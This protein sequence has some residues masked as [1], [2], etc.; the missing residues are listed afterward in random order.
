MGFDE[1]SQFNE[2]Q[3]LYITAQNRGT[4]ESKIRCYVRATFNPGGIGHAWVKKRFIDTLFDPVTPRRVQKKYFKRVDDEDVETDQFDKD[5]LSRSFV[6]STLHDNPSIAQDYL[7][8]L[9][10][11]STA[12][13]KAFIE[14][15]WDSFQGQFFKMWRKP[16]HVQRKEINPHYSKFLSL[17]YGYGAPA[18][19]GWWQIDYDGNLHRYRE[20]Y[21]EG[22]TYEALARKVR[23]MTPEGEII[24][25]CVADPAI[26]GD[27]THHRDAIEGQ[28]GAETMNS[29]WNGFTTLV[30]ADNDRIIGWGRLRERM[31]PNDKGIVGIS[32]SPECRD[33][34]RTIPTLIHDETDV[35][36]LN[37][38]GE[39]HAADEWRYAVMSRP[40]ATQK[41]E[42]K[43]EKGSLEYY[44]Q[45][46]EYQ[47]LM[48]ELE[49]A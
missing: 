6:F 26:W 33:S 17:D 12:D 19:V 28:S 14:G 48:K 31:T 37:T 5:A 15:D 3:Y 20:F 16:V 41:P 21:K 49:N 4:K 39:D 8:K 40:V 23:E 47:R 44:D 11:L 46:A 29:V 32:C 7:R 43:P 18:S 1:L 2:S 27:R 45:K 22:Y 36:D 30:K 34:I 10:Q 9:R 13:Q 24:D 25:Y 38:E 42:P 35:E